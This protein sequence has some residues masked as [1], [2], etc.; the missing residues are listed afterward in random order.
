VVR[1][2]QP[3]LVADLEQVMAGPAPLVSLYVNDFNTAAR[4]TYERL[5]FR[6]AGE[7]T[8]VLL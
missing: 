1:G 4:A 7:F 3:L 8:T 5:G 2:H 6:S